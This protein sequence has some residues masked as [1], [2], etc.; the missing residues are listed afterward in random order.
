[1]VALGDWAAANTMRMVGIGHTAK[2][3][4]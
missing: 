1:V 3:Q 4:S 2:E